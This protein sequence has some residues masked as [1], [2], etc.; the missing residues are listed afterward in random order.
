[1][2][3]GGMPSSR[4]HLNTILC[5]SVPLF[6]L[7]I[8]DI[9]LLMILDGFIPM[10]SFLFHPKYILILVQLFQ[11]PKDMYWLSWPHLSMEVLAWLVWMRMLSER[12]QLITNCLDPIVISKTVH[13]PPNCSW[14]LVFDPSSIAEQYIYQ[15]EC[16]V[17]VLVDYLYQLFNIHLGETLIYQFYSLQFPVVRSR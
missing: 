15:A 10:P 9:M 4:S 12:A 11:L 8:C 14:C 1:M 13:V 17:N 16:T 7:L 2:F 3:L 6:R 5:I